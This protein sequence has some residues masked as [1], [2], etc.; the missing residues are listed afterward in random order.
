MLQ[1]SH[2]HRNLIF[3]FCVVALGVLGYM[4]YVYKGPKVS[5]VFTSVEERTARTPVENVPQGKY[6]FD[7][8]LDLIKK[9]KETRTQFYEQFKQGKRRNKP[10]DVKKTR[11]LLSD[12]YREKIRLQQ[13]MWDERVRHTQGLPPKKKQKIQYYQ[14]VIDQSIRDLEHVLRRV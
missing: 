11:E 3:A 2:A 1:Y 7:R 6:N 14:Q 10:I 13:Y 9:T 12:V 8:M 4:M 5:T